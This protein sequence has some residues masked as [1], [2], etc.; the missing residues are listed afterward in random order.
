M[1]SIVGI[2]FWRLPENAYTNPKFIRVLFTT[3]IY[4]RVSYN[5]DCIIF[6]MA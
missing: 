4:L 5:N 3:N 2:I 6:S 1:I